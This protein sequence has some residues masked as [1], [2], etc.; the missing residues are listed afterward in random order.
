[1][2]IIAVVVIGAVGFAWYV[3]QPKSGEMMQDEAMMKKDTMTEPDAMHTEDTMM[4]QDAA[5]MNEEAASKSKVESM[6]IKQTAPAM[7]EDSG[8]MESY[9]GATLAGKSSPLLDFTKADYEKA[10][11]SGKLVVLYFYANWCPLCKAEFPVMQEAFNGLSS[12][13]VIGFR[14]NYND[15]QTDA[16]EVALAREFGVAYQHTKVFVKSG[17]QILKSPESWGKDRYLSEIAKAQ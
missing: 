8:M 10:T 2:V 7:A 3:P 1:M 15:N 6:P 16:D 12:E 9:K 11:A 14:V 5:M 4:K 17:K 13:G